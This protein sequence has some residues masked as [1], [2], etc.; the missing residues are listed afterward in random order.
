[1]ATIDD[2]DWFDKRA[3]RRAGLLCSRL[4]CKQTCPR[5]FRHLLHASQPL[6]PAAQRKQCNAAARANYVILLALL[7]FF[8]SSLPSFLCPSIHPASHAEGRQ[9]RQRRLA[10]SQAGWP[11]THPGALAQEVA[12]DSYRNRKLA[13][14]RHGCKTSERDPARSAQKESPGEEKFSTVA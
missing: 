14:V 4:Q 11:T 13:R 8:L 5:P 7:N 9:G 2:R 6:P 12:V 1:M 3:G 10:G